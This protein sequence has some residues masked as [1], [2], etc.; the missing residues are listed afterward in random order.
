MNPAYDVVILGLS[1]TSSWGN[2]HATT[3]RSL[4]RGLAQR[5][6]RVLFLERNTEWYAGNRDE[7]H[8]AGACTQLYESFEELV[9]RFEQ[10][11]SGADLVIVGSFV[12]EGARVGEWVTSVARGVCAFYD[13]DTPVTLAKLAEGGADYLTPELV[14]RYH[15]YLSFTGGPVLRR[16]ESRYGAPI[17][18]A[19]YC[20]VDPRQYRPEAC[21]L[22][23]DLGYLGTYSADRQPALDRLLLEPARQWSTGRFAVMGPMYPKQIEWPANV[24]RDI[25]LSPREH[26]RFYGA[27]RFTLNITREA[28]KQAGYSPSVRLFEAGACGVPIISDWWEGLD[29]L[30]AIGKEVLLA[31]HCT[32]TLRILRD[33]SEPQRL[34]L[35]AA[36]RERILAEHTPERRAGQLEAYWK[37][38][39]DNFSSHPA[40]RNRR[41]RQ[42]DHGLDGGLAPERQR[43]TAGRPASGETGAIPDPRG[44]HQSAGTL[45]RDG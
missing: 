31:S 42:V 19:L 10:A 35:G 1:V 21:A 22:R 25:H 5:G 9:T 8:P 37:E 4:I 44:L 13:I 41:G 34:A 32:D 16:I 12:P 26:P 45:R 30:F 24:D 27:Q 14:P 6:H 2:G 15:L 38:V 20:S 43:E 17:A 23:W 33:W 39:Y 3:Y 18:R 36:A 40:R 28:M 11:V 7:P 29:S